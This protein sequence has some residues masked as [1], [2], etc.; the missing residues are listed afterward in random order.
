VKT[1]I[2]VNYKGDHLQTLKT[3]CLLSCWSLEPPDQI[4]VDGPW[5]WTGVAKRLAIQ[6]DLHKEPTYAK[7]PNARCLRIV[8]WHLVVGNPVSPVR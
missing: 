4:S 7:R 2:S 6:M 8:F 3:L 1:L 5:H